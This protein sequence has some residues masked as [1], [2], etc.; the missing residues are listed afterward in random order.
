MELD[1]ESKLF[2]NYSKTIHPIL[3]TMSIL[4]IIGGFIVT[5]LNMESDKINMIL[6]LIMAMNG[7]TIWN[8]IWHEF[9]EWSLA[10]IIDELII[11]LL[12]G[13]DKID[14]MIKEGK[15]NDKN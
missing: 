9:K 3:F 12:G 8:N 4:F 14:K 15:I 7:V 10:L 2:F 11:G 6:G 5:I 13:Q 1:K